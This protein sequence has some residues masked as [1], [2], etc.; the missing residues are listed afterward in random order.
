MRVEVLYISRG[1]T[2][3]MLAEAIA[4]EAKTRPKDLMKNPRITDF[5]IAFIGSGN[6]GVEPDN[7][8]LGITHKVKIKDKKIA[9]FGTFGGQFNAVTE[10]EDIFRKAG[11]KII[12]KWGCRGK[13]MFFSRKG[14][15]K[16]DL[17]AARKFAKSI[18]EAKSSN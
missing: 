6:Y 8:I 15:T 12:G 9:I 14:P 13:F 5:D 3:K 7:E 17:E 18:L 4:E 10:M 1:G 16:K 2:T 11:A